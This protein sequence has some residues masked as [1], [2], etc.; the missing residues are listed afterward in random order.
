MARYN[1]R[2]LQLSTLA[3]GAAIALSACSG[4]GGNVTPSGGLNVGQANTVKTSAIAR[5]GANHVVSRIEKTAGDAAFGAHPASKLSIYD[6]IV[7]NKAGKTS[8][9][10]SSLGFEC[11]ATKE[12]G[13]GVVFAQAGMRLRSISV[14]MDSWGCESGFWNDDTCSTTPGSA[15]SLPITMNVYAVTNSPSGVP[16]VGALLAWQTKTFLIAYR[17]SANNAVCT[18]SNLG[19]FLGPV[20]KQCDNGLAS[21]ITFNFALPKVTLPSEAIV[22]VAYNTSDAGYNPIGQNAPCF[23]GPGGCGYDALN[24]SA[25]GNGGFIGSNVDPN[26]TFVNFGY[27]ANYCSGNGSG[28]ILDTPCWTGYHPEINVLATAK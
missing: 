4:A 28:F 2:F 19:R 26:G 15:F 9:H 7:T 22:S 23:T 24:V 20:D 21:K 25:D 3:L 14:V 12:F 5:P 13:D 16:G 10:I 27:P 1:G 17:P 11:C 18:G 6:S 8:S